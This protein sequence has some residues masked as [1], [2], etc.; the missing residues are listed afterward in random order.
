M[1]DHLPAFLD[2][3]RGLEPGDEPGT[4]AEM[5]ADTPKPLARACLRFAEHLG[6]AKRGRYKVLYR[7]AKAVPDLGA[8]RWAPTHVYL[9]KFMRDGRSRIFYSRCREGRLDK[10]LRKLAAFEDVKILGVSEAWMTPWSPANH[11][12]SDRGIPRYRQVP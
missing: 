8:I 2:Y 3:L 10:K 11:E 1:T 9:I 7:T 12:L 6:L 4:I 5:L